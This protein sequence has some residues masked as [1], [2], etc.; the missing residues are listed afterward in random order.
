MGLS[1]VKNLHT[2]KEIDLGA[3][4][5][6]RV[7]QKLCELRI[8]LTSNTSMYNE[9][10]DS[11]MNSHVIKWETEMNRKSQKVKHKWPIY[12]KIHEKK[13]TSLVME[14]HFLIL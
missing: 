14:M 11:K 6:Y 1:D 4:R 9:P 12:M 13:L 8:F 2:A 7:R 3:E 5:T 10:K